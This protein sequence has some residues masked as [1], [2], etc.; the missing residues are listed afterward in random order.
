MFSTWVPCCS[1]MI[2]VDLAGVLNAKEFASFGMTVRIGLRWL[3][4]DK[5]D[6]GDMLPDFRVF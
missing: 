5:M 3:L 6:N 2:W 1:P 4:I